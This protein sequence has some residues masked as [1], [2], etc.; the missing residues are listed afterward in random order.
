M[1]KTIDG[2]KIE[3]PDHSYVLEILW[4]PG[5]LKLTIFFI[6]ESTAL[7]PPKAIG[8][9]GKFGLFYHR[10]SPSVLDDQMLFRSED[11]W[12]ESWFQRNE[13]CE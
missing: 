11:W 13:M 5:P 2:S 7:A 8:E 3:E 9:I 4:P 12:N 1:Q 10:N 6:V